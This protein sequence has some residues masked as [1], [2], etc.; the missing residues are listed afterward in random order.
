MCSMENFSSFLPIIIAI[1]VAIF[2]KNMQQRMKQA[3]EAEGYEQPQAPAQQPSPARRNSTARV[4][5]SHKAANTFVQHS[6]S[7]NASNTEYIDTETNASPAEQ[8]TAS[9][10]V[11]SLETTNDARRAFI[12]AEIFNRKY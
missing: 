5:Q 6:V 1:V 7:E 2:V 12:S 8:A 10:D 9:N 3:Q 4:R 11:P